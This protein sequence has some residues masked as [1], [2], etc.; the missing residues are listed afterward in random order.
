MTAQIFLLDVEFVSLQT[1]EKVCVTAQIFLLDVE[2]AS[3]QTQRVSLYDGTD[4]FN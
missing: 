2:F 4:F 3:L 1:Q